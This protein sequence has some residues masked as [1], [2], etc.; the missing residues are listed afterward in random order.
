M[1]DR[2]R[3]T[4]V[5][6]SRIALPVVLFICAALALALHR[7]GH[8]EGDD[9]ALYLRQARSI[10][11]GNPA[12]VIA[13]NR[14]AV[15]NS[16]DGFSPIGYP[17][18][19]PLLLSPF[20]RIWGLDYDR[21]K[22]LEVGLF[23][24]W[25][26]FLHGIVRRRIGVLPALAVVAVLGTAPILLSHTDQLLSEFPYLAALGL[27]VWWLDRVVD[28]GRLIDASWTELVALGVLAAVAFNVRREGIVLPVLIAAVQVVELVRTREGGPRQIVESL[29]WRWRRLV[30]PHAA[31]VGSVVFFQLLL[32][33]ALIPDNGNSPGNIDDRWTEFP[34][35]LSEQLG[36]GERTWVGVVILALAASGIVVGLQRRPRLDGPIL[37]LAVLS[38]MTIGTHFRRVDRY[39]F[40]VTPWVL[41]FAVAACV[42]AAIALWRGRAAV[43]PWLA[44]APAALLLVAHANDLPSQLRDVSE[45]NAAGRT[46]SGPANPDNLPIFAAVDELTPPDAIVAFYRARTMTLLTD[47]LSFQTRQLDDITRSADYLAQRRRPNGWQPDVDEMVGSGFVEVWSD[48]HWILWENPH[49]AEDA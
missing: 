24:V 10:F 22:V 5:D 48:D 40:Q 18:G 36:L 43:T 7:S 11:E 45:F 16:A 14:F 30:A 42:A 47:R 49:A 21:L 28:R 33:T 20:V 29:R 31:F 35:I 15:L 4:A 26:T 3:R 34:E 8:T 2:G 44:V 19:W 27:F 46:L 25:L 37:L 38:A 32:P 9:F 6:T 13:D 12:E 1:L 41:Y 39:W 17:W 23:V